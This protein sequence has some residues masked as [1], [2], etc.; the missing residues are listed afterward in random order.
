[1][2]ISLKPEH[3][4]FIQAQ[5]ETGNYTSV[6]E[7]VNEAFKLFVERER[8]L[9]ELRQKVSVGTKQIV[10]GQVTDGETVFAQLHAKINSYE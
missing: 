5:L 10:M 9:A 8:R 2:D 6:D 4:Q 3:E 7:I 1:M